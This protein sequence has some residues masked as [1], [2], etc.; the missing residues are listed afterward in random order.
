MAVPKPA[1]TLVFQWIEQAT[2][3]ATE[4]LSIRNGDETAEVEVEGVFLDG[5][6]LALERDAQGRGNWESLLEHA[7]TAAD[8]GAADE[9]LPPA[10]SAGVALADDTTP[11]VQNGAGSMAVNLDIASVQVTNGQI[12]Y[13]DAASGLPGQ[14]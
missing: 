8:S 1:A 2:A 11:S 14:I 12:A 4:T 9:A 3:D 13:Q 10:K 6:K 7:A 5:L